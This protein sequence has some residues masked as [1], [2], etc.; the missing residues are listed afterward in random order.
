M[1]RRD[2]PRPKTRHRRAAALAALSGVV[3]GLAACSDPFRS[4]AELDETPQVLGVRAEPPDLPPGQDVTL[5]A[6]VHWP[7][8]VPTLVWLVCIPEIGQ[9]FTTCLSDQFGAAAE[10]PLCASDPAARFCIAGVGS[11]V[12]YRVPEGV[13]PDDGERHTFFVNMLATRSFDGIAAC[14]EVLAGGSPT[15]DC[16]LSLKR[17]VVTQGDVQNRNPEVSHFTRDGVV[18]GRLGPVVVDSAG[19]DLEKLSVKIGVALEVASVDELVGPDGEP[20]DT[21]LVVSWFTDCG[22]LDKTASFLDCQAQGEGGG[23]SC[24]VPE[25]GWKPK[26]SGSCRVHAVVRDGQGG[27]GWATQELEVR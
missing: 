5:D 10:P 26:A 23:P 27:I 7:G 20:T 12:S 18:L 13:F 8:V 14:G 4:V 25:V 19:A 9:D 17:V 1:A 21:T 24:Q 16:L 15:E 22:S 11:S 2:R 6:L 3:M